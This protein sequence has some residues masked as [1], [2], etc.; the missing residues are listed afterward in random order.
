MKQLDDYFALQQAIFQYFGYR[1]D[2]RILPLD[3]CR[4]FYTDGNKLLS[5]FSND[6]ERPKKPT[7]ENL[8]MDLG[9]GPGVILGLE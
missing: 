7:S 1:E 2:W 8:G 5:V 6:K 4:E 9:F 3:D